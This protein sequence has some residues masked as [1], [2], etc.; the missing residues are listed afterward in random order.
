[1]TDIIN[2]TIDLIFEDMQ[3]NRFSVIDNRTAKFWKNNIIAEIILYLEKEYA[4]NTQNTMDTLNARSSSTLLTEINELKNKL[5][6]PIENIDDAKFHFRTEMLSYE[7]ADKYINQP[8][9][10]DKYYEQIIIEANPLLR[11]HELQNRINVAKCTIKNIS[12]CISEYNGQINY[13]SNLTTDSMDSDSIISNNNLPPE[14]DLYQLQDI[15]AD[16]KLHDN[17]CIIRK[18]IDEEISNIRCIKNKWR[19]LLEDIFTARKSE[20]DKFIADK[21]ELN[22]NMPTYFHDALELISQQQ[23]NN[24]YKYFDTLLDKCAFIKS[25]TIVDI[26][27]FISEIPTHNCDELFPIKEKYTTE[28][29]ENNYNI[30]DNSI[31]QFQKTDLNQLRAEEQLELFKQFQIKIKNFR[32]IVK[33]LNIRKINDYAKTSGAIKNIY[34][35]TQYDEI[36][37][38]NVENI[39]NDLIYYMLDREIIV[40]KLGALL[41]ICT[42]VT[43]CNGNEYDR[44]GNECNQH[45]IINLEQMAQNKLVELNNE[46]K[47]LADFSNELK[48]YDTYIR[49]S[50]YKKNTDILMHIVENYNAFANV[51]DQ[52]NFENRLNH[53]IADMLN[54]LKNNLEI[55][56][57]TINSKSIVFNL[58]QNQDILKIKE[59]LK[60]ISNSL[61]ISKQKKTN[62]I[63]INM[64]DAAEANDVADMA[65]EANNIA[66]A[67]REIND[68]EMAEVNDVVDAAEANNIANTA[69]VNDVAKTAEVNDVANSAEVNDADAAEANDVILQQVSSLDEGITMYNNSN[70][71]VTTHSA[72]EYKCKVCKKNLTYKGSKPVKHFTTVSHMKNFAD[73]LVKNNLLKKEPY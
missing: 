53:A 34:E 44:H 20:L 55:D 73:W 27:S 24:K 13:L 8:D 5:P 25:P 49:R 30:L 52:I 41:M 29:L 39:C 11:V 1:M 12:K 64:T 28:Q 65:H 51:N 36:S 59:E 18:I 33:E 43:K 38:I 22:K 42:N 35:V 23:P 47:V 17:I 56:G 14:I 9:L 61:Q 60:K 31:Q 19:Y 62:K 50:V 48:Y 68:A 15:I 32:A 72:S 21:L 7:A 67:V 69:E 10:Y 71:L 4:K 45:T 3:N 46:K 16:D 57:P 6:M 54:I 2:S 63:K 66:E 37:K 40:R 70:Y 26:F 58:C